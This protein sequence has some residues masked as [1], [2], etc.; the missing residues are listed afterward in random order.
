MY[1]PYY[2]SI[3]VDNL[4]ERITIELMI[5]AHKNVI[6]IICHFSGGSMVMWTT[7]HCLDFVS[8]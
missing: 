2:K 5:S 1:P 4:L 6:V 3:V 8:M 7:T